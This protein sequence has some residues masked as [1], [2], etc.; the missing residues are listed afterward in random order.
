MILKSV[1]S[2]KVLHS[3]I[4]FISCMI[5]ITGN[6]FSQDVPVQDINSV[7]IKDK[8]YINIEGSP[9]LSDVWVTG[10]VKFVDGKNL[11]DVDLK[12]DQVRGTL[13]FKGKKNEEFEFTE[14]IKEF[15]IPPYGTFRNGFPPVKGSN[16]KTFYQ[17]LNDGK[18][19]FLKLVTKSILETKPFYSGT[20]TR[21]IDQNVK[22][23]IFK[24]DGNLIMVKNDARSIL[25]QLKDKEVQLNTF[26][27]E[28]NVNIKDDHDLNKLFQYYNSL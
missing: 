26:I 3:F 14:P 28:K 4:L 7:S 19:K 1:V 11:N 10:T 17:V 9:Y 16:E 21:T 25:A 6:T 2:P 24:S 12:F 13:I 20:I 15:M 22:Y 18:T 27:K 8:K 23:Y 5:G